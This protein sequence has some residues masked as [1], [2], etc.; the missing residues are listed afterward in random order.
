MA[1]IPE[2]FAI[3]IKPNLLSLIECIAKIIFEIK[4]Q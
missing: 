4:Q 1:A 3:Q 2:P